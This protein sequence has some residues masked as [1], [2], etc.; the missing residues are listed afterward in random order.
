MLTKFAV[1]KA[2]STDGTA[3]VA[4]ME[5]VSNFSVAHGQAGYTLSFNGK[6]NGSGQKAANIVVFDKGKPARL[7]E[8]YQP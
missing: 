2:G 8:G 4:N 3:V 1:E 6:H 7:W 5:K